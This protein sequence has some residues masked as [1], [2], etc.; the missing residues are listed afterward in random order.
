MMRSGLRKRQLVFA[1]GWLGVIFAFYIVLRFIP[2]VSSFVLSF[3][4]WDL[5]KPT[6]PFVGFQNYS[7]LL[8]DSDFLVALGNTTLFT[9][10]VVSLTLV[11]ALALA[12]ALQRQFFGRSIYETIFFLPIIIAVVPISLAWRWIY[13]PTS[14]VL[15]YLIS[16]LGMARRGWLIN[17]SLALPSIMAMTIWQRIGYNMVIFIV[18]LGEIPREYYEA[19]TV[20]GANSFQLF[21]RITV[22]LLLPVIIYLVVMNTIETFRVFTPVYVMT[23]GAQG[24][25]ASAVRVLVMDIYQNAF[26][27]FQMGYAAAESV[28]L[29]LIVLVVALLQ[30]KLFGRRGELQ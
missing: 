30:F 7:R 22:P 11:L 8:A 20:D 25:P 2:I 23:T 15:N 10:V 24:A 29:F 21:R 19:G 1:Y 28:F 6:K 5:I 3:F 4:K 27:F 17:E 13:D 18:G 14:G 16:F 9:A 26:R 12:L